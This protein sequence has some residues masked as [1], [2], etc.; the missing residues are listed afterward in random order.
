MVGGTPTMDRGMVRTPT[1][2]KAKVKSLCLGEIEID[3][4]IIT[5]A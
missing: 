1:M 3:I 5:P 2:D 4:L